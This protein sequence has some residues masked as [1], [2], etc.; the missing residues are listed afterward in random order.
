M[1]AA[2]DYVI[3]CIGNRSLPDDAIEG[4][5]GFTAWVD[6]LGKEAYLYCRM[7]R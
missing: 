4:N 7:L 5:Q 2:I 6:W 3:D 1:S